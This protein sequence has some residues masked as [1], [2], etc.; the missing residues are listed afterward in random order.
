MRR[1]VYVTPK[2]YLSFID[3]YK[4]LYKAKWKGIDT[5]QSNIQSGLAKLLEAVEGV[6]EMKKLL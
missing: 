2:S 1:N 6:G 4:A 5:D 3:L